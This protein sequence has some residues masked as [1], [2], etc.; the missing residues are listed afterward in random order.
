[1]ILFFPQITQMYTGVMANRAAP[2]NNILFHE[3]S[4]TLN[5]YVLLNASLLSFKNLSVTNLLWLNLL[6]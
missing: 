1:M 6:I 4:L 3:K 2:Y 5:L